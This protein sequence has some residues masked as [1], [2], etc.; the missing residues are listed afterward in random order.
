MGKL[1]G[2][3]ALFVLYMAVSVATSLLAAQF[4][5]WGLA[6]LHVS[7]GIWGPYL[8]LMGVSMVVGVSS[9]LSKSNK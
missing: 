4:V 2:C 9:S 5:V 3:L 8:I 6:M 1:F 7:S